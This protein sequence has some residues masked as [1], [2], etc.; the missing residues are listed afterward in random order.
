[1]ARCRICGGPH[2]AQHC[3]NAQPHIRAQPLALRREQPA[4]SQQ[5][6]IPSGPVGWNARIP[7]TDS[8][9]IKGGSCVNFINH[10]REKSPQRNDHDG[11]RKSSAPGFSGADGPGACVGYDCG[12]FPCRINGIKSLSISFFAGRKPF[13]TN[14][15]RGGSGRGLRQ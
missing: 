3:P 9:I 12:P 5:A 8:P 13:T 10:S 6:L 4:L 7:L 15:R 2:Y 14:H 11:G 1:M